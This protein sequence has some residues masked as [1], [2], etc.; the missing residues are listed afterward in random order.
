MVGAHRA[1]GD[2]VERVAARLRAERILDDGREDVRLAA[3]VGARSCKMSVRSQY[4]GRFLLA[5][6]TRSKTLTVPDCEPCGPF[7]RVP[8][9]SVRNDQ[10]GSVSIAEPMP[11]KPPPFLK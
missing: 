3:D 4:S 7:E 2:A 8:S 10:V 6:W 1:A 9:S 5:S 11:T